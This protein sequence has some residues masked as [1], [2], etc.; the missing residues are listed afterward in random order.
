[1]AEP[2]ELVGELIELTESGHISWEGSIYNW[3][4]RT[5]DC[6][7]S[8]YPSG[9]LVARYPFENSSLQV[10]IDGYEQIM[11][12][13]IELLHRKFPVERLPSE[14]ERL[15]HVLDCVK[16]QVSTNGR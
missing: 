4:T 3:Q 15:Q 5:G 14:E 12:P 10:R 2:K 1:M 6:D 8:V 13:L 9:L 11:N 7:F 16:N